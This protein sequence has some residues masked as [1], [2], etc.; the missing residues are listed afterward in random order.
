MLGIRGCRLGILK[1]ALYR[2]QVRAL[3]QAAVTRKRAGGNPVVEIM[4]PLIV[5]SPELKLLEQWVRT[6]ADL[7]L[8]DAGVEIPYQIGRA[9]V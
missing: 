1:P 9:H 8:H 3:M 4:I 2:M 7:V 6:E 5:S